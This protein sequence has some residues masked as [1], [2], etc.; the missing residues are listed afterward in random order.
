[1]IRKYLPIAAQAEQYQV[2]ESKITAYSKRH[3]LQSLLD[4]LNTRAKQTNYCNGDQRVK[5]WCKIVG[6]AQKLLPAHAV[7]KYYRPDRS[8]LDIIVFGAKPLSIFRNSLFR[9]NSHYHWRPVCHLPL[10]KLMN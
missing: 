7:N 1:M 2:L 8:L 10:H 4:A 9:L 3:D 6:G 5:H